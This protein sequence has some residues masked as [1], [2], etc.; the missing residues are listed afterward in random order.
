MSEDK[1][2]D[3][4]SWAFIVFVVCIGGGLLLNFAVEANNKRENRKWAEKIEYENA[5][6]QNAEIV[7][8]KPEKRYYHTCAICGH[9]GWEDADDMDDYVS[10]CEKCGKW[11]CGGCSGCCE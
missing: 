1:K 10:W 11:R 9:R 6:P 5:H 2:I 8:T 7:K 3:G 4:V